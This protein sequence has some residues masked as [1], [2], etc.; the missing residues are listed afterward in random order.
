VN[1][2]EELTTLLRRSSICHIATTMPDGSPQLTQTWGDTDG[3]HVLINTVQSFQKVRNIERDPRVAL[4]VA[5]PVD[6]SRYFS[7]RGR[8]VHVSTEGAAEHV[9]ALSQ[10]YLGRAYPWPA[11]RDEIRLILAIRADKIHAMNPKATL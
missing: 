3:E 5:D 9:E 8:V 10:R 4:S 7:I 2:T 6:P 11:G 1:L